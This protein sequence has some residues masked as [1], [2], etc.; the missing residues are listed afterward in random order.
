MIWIFL[1]FSFVFGLIIGSFTNCFVWRLYKNESLWGRSYCP[2]CRRTIAWY[3]NM[4]VLSF[5]LLSGRCRRCR[6]KISPQYPLVEAATALLF[7]ASFYFVARRLI[8]EGIF[9]D[10][11]F[12]LS[13]YKFILELTKDWLAIFTVM[14]VLIYDWRWYLIPDK[15]ILPAALIVFGIN[16]FLGFNWL[17]LAYCVFAGGGFFLL[18]L[19]ISRGRWIGGGDIRLGVFAGAL[20]GS[21]DLLVLAILLTYFI[22]SIIGV[23][24]IVVGKK[25]WESKV[26]LGVFWAPALVITIFWGQK[27]IGWYLGLFS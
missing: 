7:S 9:C 21:F 22:G 8:P 14:A 6:G 16:L 1:F 18:Q 3:D 25:H 4:P 11:L 10:N 27:I 5:F 24:M 15:A 20:L 26:P 23:G 2:H 13:D 12:L 19:I 17:A